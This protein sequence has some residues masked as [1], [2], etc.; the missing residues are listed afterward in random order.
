LNRKAPSRKTIEAAP[1]YIILYDM[2]SEDGEDLRALPFLQ[3]RTRLE[4][5]FQRVQPEGMA[6][7]P[8][9]A[10]SSMEDLAHH[11]LASLDKRAVEGVMLKRKDSPYVAG[12]PTGLWYKWKRDP[13]VADAVLMYAQRGHGKRSSLYSDF[14][15]GLWRGNDI[16]PIGKAYFGFTDV[17]LKELDKWVRH[18]TIQSFGPVREVEKHL[19]LEIAFDAVRRSTRHK[20]G[21]ALRFPRINRIRWDKPAIEADRIEILHAMLE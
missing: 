15:F 2:L 20:S 1:G 5:W 11:R 10:F 4:R 8:L 21:F 19:V 14:T 17:E 13:R 3:R 9:I 16:L 12:R 6:L 18:H 7:S